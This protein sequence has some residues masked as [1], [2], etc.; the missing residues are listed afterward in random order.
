MGLIN[1]FFVQAVLFCLGAEC[2]VLDNVATIKT[3][4]TYGFI[5]ND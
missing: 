1:F 2:R 4:A 3:N 5:S